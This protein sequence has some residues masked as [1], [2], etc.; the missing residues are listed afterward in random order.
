MKQSDLLI[1]H[2][3]I[4]LLNHNIKWLLLLCIL[5]IINDLNSKPT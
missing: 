2:R 3:G 4:F 1:V 5:N